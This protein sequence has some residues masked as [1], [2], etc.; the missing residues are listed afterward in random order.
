MTLRIAA[1]GDNV[2]DCYLAQGLMFAGG[3][4][5]NVSVFAAQTG[6]TTS[7]VGA[8]SGDA[9]GRHIRSALAT[10]NVNISHLRVV[11]GITAYCIVGHRAGDR[12][13]ITSDLGVSR[14]ELSAAD[15]DFIGGHEVAHIGQSSG[16]DSALDEVTARTRLS[17][18]FSTRRDDEH[19]RQV[20]PLC[21]LASFSGGDLGEA[22]ARQLA[23]RAVEL[24][25]QWALVT[26]GPQGAIL[27]GAIGTRTSSAVPGGVTDTLGAGDTFIAHALVG[28][29]RGEDPEELLTAAARHAAETCARLGAFGHGVPISDGILSSH[30]DLFPNTAQEGATHD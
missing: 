8:V 30:P 1:V 5:V 22:D 16:F 2:V 26:R 21:Y 27:A 25:A 9:A 10:E 14:F 19:L 7:Y 17:Y 11:D 28:L 29:L 24:G 12:V 23:Q 20:A 4:T 3:N 6:A 15:L 13:F 18:D